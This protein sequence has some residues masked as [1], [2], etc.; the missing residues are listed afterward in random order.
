MSPDSPC[1]ITNEP[2]STDC[3]S[4]AS[5]IALCSVDEYDE[6]KIFV[7]TTCRSN[8]LIDLPL[9]TTFGTYFAASITAISPLSY[10]ASLFFLSPPPAFALNSSMNT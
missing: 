4:N 5:T 6:N 10:T 7:V 8:S 2:A 3:S 1:L 9:A